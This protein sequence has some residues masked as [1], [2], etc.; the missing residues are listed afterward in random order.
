MLNFLYLTGDL[1]GSAQRLL[2]FKPARPHETGLI[3]LGDAGANYYLN[4]KDD[5]FKTQLN[6]LGYKIYLLRGNHEA[7]PEDIPDINKI[8]DEDL[9][10]EVFEQPQY[11]NIRYLL[12]GGTYTFKDKSILTIGGAYSVDKFYRLAQ[13]WQW[14]HNEQLNEQERESIFNTIK[15]K[16]FDFV[17]THT[18]PTQFQPTDLFLRT[19][20]QGLVDNTTEKWLTEIEK[21]IDYNYWL[22]G[23]YHKDRIID[24][25]VIMLMHCIIDIEAITQ[26]ENY[27]ILPFG[28]ELSK[29]FYY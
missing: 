9:K 5:R 21:N 3:V 15:D 6:N 14:F 17:L 25:K 11:P 29:Q 27:Q 18:C 1:H 16:H 12:D 24:R 13:G 2:D 4:Q 23:H 22:F 26:Y 7:R 19:I 28:M 8:Y 20:D 10:G